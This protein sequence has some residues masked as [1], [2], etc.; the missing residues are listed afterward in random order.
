M[1]VK[2]Q[3]VIC[4]GQE[5]QLPKKEISFF[6]HVPRRIITKDDIQG[7]DTIKLSYHPTKGSK[8]IIKMIYDE[9][10]ND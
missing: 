8:R 4:F 3:S 2:D 7:L 6:G 5:I 10:K 1:A 9:K